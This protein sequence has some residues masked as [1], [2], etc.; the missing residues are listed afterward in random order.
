[1]AGYSK[2]HSEPMREAYR[3]AAQTLPDF[4]K[5]IRLEGGR[6]CTAKHE[7]L[8]RTHF[9]MLARAWLY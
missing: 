1:M 4:I 8:T 7:H 3:P 6:F 2:R 5:H 9:L